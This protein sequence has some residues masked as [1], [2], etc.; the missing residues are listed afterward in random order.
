MRLGCIYL[1]IYDDSQL[2]SE[3]TVDTNIITYVEYSSTA[4]N[5]M[6]RC[7]FMAAC[8]LLIGPTPSTISQHPVSPSVMQPS[9]Q[10]QSVTPSP[11]DYHSQTHSGNMVACRAVILVLESTPIIGC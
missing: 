8:Y 3:L 1:M 4:T 7:M 10:S 11:T 9:M 2:Q 5:R 6:Y